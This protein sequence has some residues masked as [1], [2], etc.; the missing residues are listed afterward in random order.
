[1][2][3]EVNIKVNNIDLTICRLVYAINRKIEKEEHVFIEMYNLSNQGFFDTANN[4]I[5]MECVGLDRIAYSKIIKKLQK[6]GLISKDG[7]TIQLTPNLI[8]KNINKLTINKYEN[9]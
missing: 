9:K 8:K 6:K 3:T 1:M 5:I 4:K 7:G 2:T